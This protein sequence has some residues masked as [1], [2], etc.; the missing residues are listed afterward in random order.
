LQSPISH[1]RP[2]DVERPPEEG[3]RPLRPRAPP[4]ASGEGTQPASRPKRRHLSPSGAGLR[5]CKW[6][7][8]QH[9]NQAGP[10]RP[11]RV[12]FC[13]AAGKVGP[14]S[15]RE[16][17]AP[18]QCRVRR[19][20]QPP[21]ES[22]QRHSGTSAARQTPKASPV[23]TFPSHPF[24]GSPR[25][26]AMAAAL[27]LLTRRSFRAV[28]PR[29]RP[30]LVPQALS[31]SGALGPRFPPFRPAHAHTRLCSGPSKYPGRPHHRGLC[32]PLYPMV[33]GPRK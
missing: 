33:C 5:C 10:R 1:Y 23:A 9:E 16:G 8:S 27:S 32:A 6:L 28:P 17:V 25:L 21:S 18:A 4:R 2:L 12:P 24:P 13:W 11:R 26:P 19:M 15:G 20:P 7:K 14:R 22:S 30:N 31:E 29:E 3:Q